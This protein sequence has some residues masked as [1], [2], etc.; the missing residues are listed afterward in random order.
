MNPRQKRT[1]LIMGVLTGLVF[2]AVVIASLSSPDESVTAGETTTTATAPTSSTSEPTTTISSSTT[3]ET[4]SSTTTSST[5]TSPTTTTT[6]PVPPTMILLE[7]GFGFMAPGSE[8]LTMATFGSEAETALRAITEA[9]GP[10]DEDSGWVPSFSLFG[11]CPGEEVRGVRWATLWA[12][13]TDG[14]TAWRNDG[15][16]HFFAYL[17]SVFYD[18]TQ[19]LGLLT[20]E[21]VGL[22][23]TVKDLKD[24]Y[25]KGVEI[26][27]E[28]FIDGYLFTIDVPEPG[29]LGGGLTGERNDDLITSID[30]GQ[31]CGE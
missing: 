2:V 14:D 12:L 31:G 9:L 13:M 18:E 26:T 10:P 30:G 22:G 11:T 19:S 20:E 6:N 17:N 7:N 4:T 29:Q 24:A 27:Y 23:D 21:L 5:T 15:V 1:I 16:P 3:T 25:G 8:T 28:E